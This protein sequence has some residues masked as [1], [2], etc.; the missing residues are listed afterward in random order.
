MYQHAVKV[1]GKV[2]SHDQIKVHTCAKAVKDVHSSANTELLHTSEQ[3]TEM[4]YIA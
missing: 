4:N 1:H 3:H 2:S